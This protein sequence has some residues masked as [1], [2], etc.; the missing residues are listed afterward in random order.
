MNMELVELM[1]SIPRLVTLIK[2]GNDM[3]CCEAGG[4]TSE[5]YVN[6][7]DAVNEIKRKLNC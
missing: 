7:I 4:R 1:N 3:Y 5:W 2:S 6:P